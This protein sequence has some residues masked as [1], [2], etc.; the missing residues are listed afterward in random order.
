MAMNTQHNNTNKT[1]ADEPQETASAKTAC[2]SKLKN[3]MSFPSAIYR[4]ER[5]Y[6]CTQSCLRVFE[7][8]PDLFMAGE[9]EHP[10]GGESSIL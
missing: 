5:V 8:D 2:G 4:G 6:F 10:T 1:D 7:Q 3:P 9:I